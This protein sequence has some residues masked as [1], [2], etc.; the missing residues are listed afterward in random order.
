MALLGGLLSSQGRETRAV[1]RAL[2]DLGERK[3][4]VRV[5]VE[6]TGTSFFT[7]LSLRKNGLLLARPRTLA[8]GMAKGLCVRLTLPNHQRRQV[9]TEVLVPN[10][11]LPMT[12]KHAMICSVPTAFSGQC[13]RS[14]DRFDTSRFKNLT[15]HLAD[16]QQTFRV[17]DLSATGLRIFTGTDGEAYA[18]EAGNAL[19]AGTLCV[20]RG[21]R[22]ELG[23]ITTR[24]RA[25]NTV[26]LSMAVQRAGD[27]QKY[28]LNLLNRLQETELK[29]IRID[30]A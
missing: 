18:F 10:V 24:S 6:G 1:A 9:R 15:L 30:T 13:Q 28:L 23:D 19:G 8:G 21:I 11:Q 7:V 22:I 17:I 27:S 20:G 12:L 2:A 5:E 25:G 29:R 4:P 3:T 16:W 26:G 14:A